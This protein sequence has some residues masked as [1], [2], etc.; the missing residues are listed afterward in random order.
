MRH[1]EPLAGRPDPAHGPPPRPTGA[2][3]SP[4]RPGPGEPPSREQ[5]MPTTPA[6]AAGVRRGHGR[7]ASPPG[8]VPMK[9]HPSPTRT[10]T[11]TRRS[12][13]CR[14][15]RGR[16]THPTPQAYPAS[17]AERHFTEPEPGRGARLFATPPALTAG[18]PGTSGHCAQPV[19]FAAE[20]FPQR[21]M[22]PT[23]PGVLL[24]P[25]LT[26]IEPH[27]R[28]H[29][30]GRLPREPRPDMRVQERVPVPQDLQVDP[31]ERRIQPP[32]HPLDRFTEQVEVGQERQPLRPRQV[33][34][35][36]HTRLV[37]EQN[38]VTRQELHIPDHREPCCQPPQ[39]RRVLPSQRSP[40]PVRPPVTSHNPN[41]PSM[42]ETRPSPRSPAHSSQ[43]TDKQGQGQP[44][45]GF[46]RF[47][48]QGTGGQ[49]TRGP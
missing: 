49:K 34:Q 22:L 44:R 47:R 35:P 15:G 20:R 38:R 1:P 7:P 8:A 18:R 46:Q 4:G 25:P 23:E 5:P 28:T 16:H 26:R 21:V 39:H 32:A 14:P 6:E 36:L 10:R 24:T 11:R 19:Q 3:R 30:M 2:G 13:R 45:A 43:F 42:T 41:P 9:H 17:T 33:R 29:H 27:R 31:P 37:H 12:G 48:R 40:D